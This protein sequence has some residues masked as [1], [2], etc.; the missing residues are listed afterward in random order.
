MLMSSETS[1]AWDVEEYL[2]M[3]G[4]DDVNEST[5]TK[6][7]ESV[8]L[9]FNGFPID[10]TFYVIP[11]FGGDVCYFE[12]RTD[13]EYGATWSFVVEYGGRCIDFYDEP[14]LDLGYFDFIVPGYL[15]IHVVLHIN[16]TTD[17]VYEG[18][19]TLIWGGDA[20]LEESYDSSTLTIP[21]I[22]GRHLEDVCSP[23]GFDGYSAE[24]TLDINPEDLRDMEVIDERPLL[25]F[26]TNRFYAKL[27]N[28]G[29]DVPKMDLYEIGDVIQMPLG[30][31]VL[32]PVYYHSLEFIS[33]P[34][35]WGEIEYVA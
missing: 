25:G 31:S 10:E 23:T 34:V 19:C 33:N 12:E 6:L 29:S 27:Y 20:T 18:N 9:S 14:D 26:T 4:P 5:P 28:D 3:W 1:Y 2:G 13:V 16:G 7:Y 30:T 21:D 35:S 17:F 24:Y 11:P 8:Y 32:Y 22:S 15:K